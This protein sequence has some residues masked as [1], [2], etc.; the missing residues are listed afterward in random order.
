MD[1]FPIGLLIGVIKNVN[2]LKWTN[3]DVP[4]ESLLKSDLKVT[5]PAFRQNV[6]WNAVA[7]WSTTAFYKP[8]FERHKAL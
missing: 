2:K 1:R 4:R 7:V 6:M 8:L 3:R 5:D